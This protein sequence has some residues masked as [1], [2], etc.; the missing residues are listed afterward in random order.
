MRECSDADDFIS[1][2]LF[3][4]FSFFDQY[5]HTLATQFNEHG[6]TVFSINPTIKSFIYVC[7]HRKQQKSLKKQ[8]I[9]MMYRVLIISSLYMSIHCKRLDFCSSTRIFFVILLNHHSGYS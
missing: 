6:Y 7:K 1:V 2:F 9:T 3:S 8:T 4:F 5:Y